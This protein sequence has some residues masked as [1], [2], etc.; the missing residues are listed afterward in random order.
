[1]ASFDLCSRPHL[2][3]K[4]FGGGGGCCFYQEKHIQKA[5]NLLF[6]I[7]SK[8]LNVIT[9]DLFHR[10][11]IAFLKCQLLRS[12]KQP[13]KYMVPINTQLYTISHPTSHPHT[14]TQ[15]EEHLR[16]TTGQD[17][18]NIKQ[19]GKYESIKPKPPMAFVE[20]R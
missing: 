10:L 2:V 15:I 5:Y 6:E 3:R 7:I 9:R 12:V 19:S 11:Y 16:D 17:T 13:E 1:M 20:K 14:Q 18:T 8:T 4:G